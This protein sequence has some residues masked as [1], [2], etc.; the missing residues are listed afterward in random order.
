MIRDG[1]DPNTVMASKPSA[2]WARHLGA[3]PLKRMAAS[4][5]GSD[6]DPTEY[7]VAAR[8]TRPTAGS[9]ESTPKPPFDCER[10]ISFTALCGHS[11]QRFARPRSLPRIARHLDGYRKPLVS[12]TYENKAGAEEAH[13]L[14]AEVIVRAAVTIHEALKRLGGGTEK[15]ALRLRL[16]L[17]PSRPFPRAV[18]GITHWSLRALAIAVQAMMSNRTGRRG[19]LHADIDNDGI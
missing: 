1:G 4:W 2:E 6:M 15:S 17:E 3:S 11:S 13:D 16:S 10:E 7:K 18:G 9:P 19:R 12:L 14:S 5:S 8:E